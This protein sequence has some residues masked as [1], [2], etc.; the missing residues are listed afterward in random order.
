MLRLPRLRHRCSLI[1]AAALLLSFT[2][3]SRAQ[4][5][6]SSPPT[7]ASRAV[8]G[9]VAGTGRIAILIAAADDDAPIAHVRVT[10]SA[11]MTVGAAGTAPGLPAAGNPPPGGASSQPEPARM[12][13]DTDDAG[14]IEFTGLPAALYTV[15]AIPPAGFVRPRWISPVRVQDHGMSPLTTVRLTRTGTIVGRVIDDAG[16]PMRGAAVRALGRSEGYVG[17][18]PSGMATADTSGRFRISEL[19][20]GQYVVVVV[21]IFPVTPGAETASGPGR[22]LGFA[23]TYYP[24]V[25]D[26]DAARRVVVAAG[27]FTPDVD[28]AV[29]LAPLGRVAGVA[30]DAS[31]MPLTSRNSG[32]EEGVVRLVRKGPFTGFADPRGEPMGPDGSFTFPDVPPGDYVVVAEVR[33]TEGPPSRTGRGTMVVLEGAQVAVTVNGD[34]RTVSVRTNLGATLSG[35]VTWAGTPLAQ[36]TP[37]AASGRRI[38]PRHPEVKAIRTWW[39]T[40][41]QAVADGRQDPTAEIGTFRII[42]ARG[43]V[44]LNAWASGGVLKSIQRGGVDLTVTP[45]ELTGTER[46]TDIEIVFTAE[47]GALTG[48]VTDA[49]GG[50][51][52]DRR[53]LVFPDEP[54]LWYPMS[55]FVRSMY[56]GRASA[57]PVPGSVSAAAP[58]GPGRFAVARLLPGKYLVAVQELSEA[59]LSDPDGFA[60]LRSKATPV[61]IVAGGTASVEIQVK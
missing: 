38:D 58:T 6:S 43:S 12:V 47:T 17:L 25:P 46:I 54:G 30:T 15:S 2:S 49:G 18:A 40:A 5:G 42:G 29:R 57:A 39:T 23:Q 56:T 61:T 11:T 22:R 37:G 16:R 51:L 21:P 9:Q 32:G 7:V 53:A 48:L 35:R 3:A 26:V 41:G 36:D 24:G 59:V 33:R 4:V 13:G 50:P 52:P 31:G 20:P 45:L 55:S 10:I 34:E 27:Q 44:L 19:T 28:F 60:A 14:R 1:T 8:S